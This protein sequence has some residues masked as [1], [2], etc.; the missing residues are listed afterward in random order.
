MLLPYHRA[1]NLD[2]LKI[3]NMYISA[4]ECTFVLTALKRSGP[5]YYQ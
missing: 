2:N 4:T 5:C 3:T 1:N